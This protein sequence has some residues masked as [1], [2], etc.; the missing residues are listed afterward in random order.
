MTH[1]DFIEKINSELLYIKNTTILSEFQFISSNQNDIVN[2]NIVFC[3]IIYVKENKRYIIRI[4]SSAISKDK[5][6]VFI[7]IDVLNVIYRSPSNPNI[8]NFE[9]RHKIIFNGNLI[10]PESPYEFSFPV[11]I[12]LL[13]CL[14]GL[15][16]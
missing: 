11:F 14:E 13:N 12:G 1:L 3:E 10:S 2:D 7:K 15:F 5:I 6:P 8:S 16:N 4:S 9:I